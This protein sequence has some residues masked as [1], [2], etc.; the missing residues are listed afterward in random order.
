MYRFSDYGGYMTALKYRGI[1]C[2]DPK[3]KIITNCDCDPTYE[4]FY[5]DKTSD[6][7]I[8]IITYE[9][10]VTYIDPPIDAISN[11]FIRNYILEADNGIPNATEKKIVCNIDINACSSPIGSSVALITEFTGAFIINNKKYNKYNFGVGGGEPLELLWNSAK[12]GWV[13]LKYDGLFSN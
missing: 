7:E 11:C 4:T 3:P 6:G 9:K 5:T 10:D 13:V 8:I 12:S 2:C 1:Y